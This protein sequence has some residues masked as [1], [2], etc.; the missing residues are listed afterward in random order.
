MSGG[1]AESLDLQGEQV[2]PLLQ[3]GQFDAKVAFSGRSWCDREIGWSSRELVLT[4]DRGA[5][6]SGTC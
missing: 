1:R 4:E 3:I 2:V 6:D 5:E